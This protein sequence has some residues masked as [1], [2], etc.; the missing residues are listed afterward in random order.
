VPGSDE[1]A[2]SRLSLA[3]IYQP[4]P[5]GLAVLARALWRRWR[6]WFGGIGDENTAVP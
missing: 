3:Y 2:D 6:R 4:A 1:P 5:F